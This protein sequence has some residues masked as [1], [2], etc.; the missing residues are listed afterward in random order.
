MFRVPE[1]I[2]ITCNMGA[3]NLPDMYIL[4]P[5]PLGLWANKSGKSFVPML[6]LLYIAM[7][8][9]IYA[10]IHLKHKILTIYP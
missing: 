10:Y 1:V 6:Q 8:I 3:H 5:A 2:H 4:R 7:Y 9:A